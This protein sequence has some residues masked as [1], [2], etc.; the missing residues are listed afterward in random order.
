MTSRVITEARH[1]I[2]GPEHQRLRQ[3]LI[4]NSAEEHDWRIPYETRLTVVKR[5]NG[6]CENCGWSILTG[7]LAIEPNKSGHCT[8]I[9][10][11][12]KDKQ[13]RNS[14]MHHIRYPGYGREMPNDLELWCRSCHA[15]YHGKDE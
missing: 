6:S 1:A 9:C 12:D 2:P 15:Q 3:S 8:L 7:F 4:Y 11:W 5:A 10:L 14:N 13:P